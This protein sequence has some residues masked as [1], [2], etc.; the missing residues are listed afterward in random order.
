M[1]SSILIFDLVFILTSAVT[2][3]VVNP[4]GLLRAERFS[5]LGQVNILRKLIYK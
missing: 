4:A 1:S 2:S 5:A 3:K